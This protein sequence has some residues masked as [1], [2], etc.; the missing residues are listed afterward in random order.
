[1][2]LMLT[3]PDCSRH[4]GAVDWAA[5]A[6]A[7]HTFAIIKATEG[8]SY[9]RVDWFQ[10]NAPKVRAAGLVLGAYHFLRRGSAAGQA[11]YFVDIVG[12]FDGV[13]AVLDVETAADG[14]KPGL[15]E[16]EAFAAEFRRLVPGHPLVVY[17]GRWYWHGVLGNPHG[18]HVGPLWHSEYDTGS[19]V[20][21]GPELDNYGGWGS[22][23]IWQ[24]TSTGRCPGVAGD[25]DLNQFFGDR[26]QLAALTGGDDMAL[27]QAQEDAL[28]L[29]PAMNHRTGQIFALLLDDGPIGRRTKEST[30]GVRSLL[31]RD[32]V[33][34]DEAQLAAALLP[35]VVEALAPEQL[36]EV[37]VAAVP[38]A[39]RAELAAAL[40]VAP[41]A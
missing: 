21:D 22:C 29:L 7:G 17:T 20:A 31:A 39:V 23:T 3:G 28:A 13:L 34:V 36:V 9:S 26:A 14:S 1:M 35:G 12:D 15:A 24:Y 10:A 25:C 30:I 38:K 41:E 6:R 37:L 5:V 16:V 4:Q 27:T 11:R 2:A 18:A 40:A 32:G 33:D 8:T 19:E